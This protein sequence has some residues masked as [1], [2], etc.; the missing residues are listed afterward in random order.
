M[1]VFQFHDI[2]AVDVQSDAP[3]A[4]DFFSAEYG[5]HK[6]ASA[7]DSLPRIS[8]DFRMNA[9]APQDYTRHAHKLIARW[10]YRLAISPEKVEIRAYGNQPA[11]P[12][13]HHMLVHPSLRWLSANG[14]TLLLHAGAVARNG[15]SLIF[16]GK[17]GAGKTTTTSLVLASSPEWLLH[18]DDYVFIRPGRESLAYVTR[19]HL[20]L[21]LLK[22][23]PLV[24]TRLSGWERTRLEFF[25]RLREWSGERIKWPVRLGPEQLWPDRQ[26]ANLA[27]PA[28]ILL[29]ER[30]DSAQ[31]IPVDD[32][33]SAAADLLEMNFGEAGHFL[34][35]LEKSGKLDSAWL[36]AWKQTELGLMNKILNTIPTYRLVLPRSN[37]ATEVQR[38]MLPILEKLVS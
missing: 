35:L 4:Q 8:I 36:E 12:M 28:G 18:A 38:Q 30:G 31:L 7:P 17:G 9:A 29:L 33:S 26:I 5:Y 25:G 3:F 1:T 37:D 24:G 2:A 22:W 15:K 27:T 21:S 20:Y 11:V 32:L 34:H 13:V 6:V 23:V 16:T 14:G 10:A 19:S